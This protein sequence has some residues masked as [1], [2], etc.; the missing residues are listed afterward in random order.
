MVLNIQKY[1]R[2]RAH[3]RKL[4]GNIHLFFREVTWYISEAEAL[5][6]TPNSPLFFRRTYLRFKGVS[7]RHDLWIGRGFR[8]LKSGNLNLGERCALGDS[9]SIGNHGLITIGD[10]FI[11]ASGLRVNSGTHDPITLQPKAIP[12][13]IG[14]RVWCGINVTILAGVSIG[15]DV[16]VGAGSLVCKDIPSNSIAVGNPARV[17][18]KLSRKADQNIWTWISSKNL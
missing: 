2:R 17:I 13:T 3:I 16:V 15:S 18:K 4:I 5:V 6:S 12:I 8:L 11:G 9:V 1:E 7:H 14:D 10:D